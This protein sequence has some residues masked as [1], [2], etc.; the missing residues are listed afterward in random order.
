MTVAWRRGKRWQRAGKLPALGIALGLLCGMSALAGCLT[1]P[2]RTSVAT[3]A[4]EM[5]VRVR[6]LAKVD[7]ADLTV[8][9]QTRTV[10]AAQVREE[11]T[12]APTDG[13]TVAVNGRR[14]HGTLHLVPVGNAFDVVNIVT[15]DEYLEGVVPSESYSKWPAEALRAQAIASRTYAIY[16]IKSRNDG[17]AYYD[18]HAD[19]RSQAY[20]GVEAE[21]EP[22]NAAV[23]ATRGIVLATGA[24]GHEKIFCAYFSST[25]GGATASGQD[26]FD[27]PSPPLKERTADG[28]TDAKR[29]RWPEFSITKAELTRRIRVYGERNQMSIAQVGNVRSIEVSERNSVAR[30]SKFAVTD[31]SG[32]RFTLEAEQMRNAANADGPKDV[33]FLSSFFQPVDAGDSIRITDGR[34]WGH[35]VGMCQYCAFGWS[36]RGYD[37]KAI[38]AASYPG[39]VLV[40]A[41]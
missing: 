37:A 35:G 22:T 16:Q 2:A 33:Q 21:A 13:G 3:P 5:T 31:E 11:R 30:P 39:S 15:L 4:G 40:R 14:Y 9:G 28:C 6:V 36:K 20:G 27:D 12:L 25:C 8:N 26:V 17:G 38:L 19:V 29:Y 7:T 41:Y 24:K 23:S 32:K 18:L 1:T 34:G 10:T